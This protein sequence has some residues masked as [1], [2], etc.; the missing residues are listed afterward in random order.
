MAHEYNEQNVFDLF[1]LL[2]KRTKPFTSLVDIQP[3]LI[4]FSTKPLTARKYPQKMHNCSLSFQNNFFVCVVCKD[5]KVS[6]KFAKFPVS[7]SNHLA[8]VP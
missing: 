6:P 8:F 5:Y 4:D 2:R 7:L 3:G 1:G